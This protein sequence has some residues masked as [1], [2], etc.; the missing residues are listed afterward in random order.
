MNQKIRPLVLLCMV[1]F[2]PSVIQAQQDADNA[3]LQMWKA[4]IAKHFK[5]LHV[6]GKVIDQY[7]QPVSEAQVKVSW[8][9]VRIP[10]PD[11]GQSKWIDAN[12]AGEWKITINRP[13]RVGVQDLK[14]K[15]FEFDR[16]TSSYFA[17]PNSQD[18]IRQT[19]KQNP[20]VMTM[21][22]K[23]ESTFLIHNKGRVDFLPP[24]EVRRIDLL[25]KKSFSVKT[26]PGQSD[27]LPWDLNAEAMFSEENQ[28]WEIVVSSSSQDGGG[29]LVTDGVLYE[30]PAEGYAGELRVT[31]KLR[32]R[33]D[34]YV[35]FCLKSRTPSIYSRVDVMFSPGKDK[36]IMTYNSWANPYGLRN[37]E[38]N[39]D[40]EKG[41]KLR[42]Q[43]ERATKADLRIGKR[44]KKPDLKALI[45]AEKEKNK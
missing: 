5:Q 36:C 12:T 42:S 7:G 3:K 25:E 15:G 44:P 19:S 27:A 18:L 34:Y 38:Y 2:I 43:L 24:G 22:K 20:L 26:S 6:Y 40:L 14:K 9:E 35:S 30:A 45:K 33:K 21:R 16:K 11:P 28:S 29:I 13:H 8:T 32:E 41:W 23:G 31:A 4:A 17:A 1:L 10:T 37:L 39:E